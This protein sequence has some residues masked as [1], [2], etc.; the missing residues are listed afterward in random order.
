MGC[1]AEPVIAVV[2]ENVNPQTEAIM[3]RLLVEFEIALRVSKRTMEWLFTYRLV[4]LEMT[5]QQN[6]KQQVDNNNKDAR[7]SGRAM[8]K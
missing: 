6:D 3:N 8:K 4:H 7:L 2:F 5:I 1:L